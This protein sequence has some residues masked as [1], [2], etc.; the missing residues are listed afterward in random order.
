MPTRKVWQRDEEENVGQKGRRTATI[1]Q[2]YDRVDL[3]GGPAS[4][5]MKM[6]TT[7]PTGHPN[8]GVAHH[9]RQRGSL[10]RKFYLGLLPFLYFPPESKAE[11][12]CFP[13]ES[14]SQYTPNTLNSK[15]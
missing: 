8:A 11:T 7:L 12:P 14:R 15:S 5:V 6:R 10:Y 9:Y 3:L 1:G 4:G 13:G 2:F